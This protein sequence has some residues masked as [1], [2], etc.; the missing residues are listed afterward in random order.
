LSVGYLHFFFPYWGNKGERLTR[1]ISIEESDSVP[2]KG[3]QFLN[4]QAY[5]IMHI[6]CTI[7]T[8]NITLLIKN[9]NQHLTFRP[10]N[11]PFK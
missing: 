9:R 6:Y 1:G 2:P 7:H 11:K 4:A 8:L 3:G 10:F 5:T